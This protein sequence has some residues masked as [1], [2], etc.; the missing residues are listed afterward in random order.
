MDIVDYEHQ[1]VLEEARLRRE[2]AERSHGTSAG[3]P[4]GCDGSGWQEIALYEYGPL[5]G[6]AE[7]ETVVLPWILL[8]ACECNSVTG[9]RVW[10][11]PDWRKRF[12]D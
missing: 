5:D 1:Q 10:R 6:I 2:A 4:W 11:W 3:C 8:F 12:E 9:G 7:P